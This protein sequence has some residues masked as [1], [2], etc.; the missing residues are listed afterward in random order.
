MNDPKIPSRAEAFDS[1]LPD[2]SSPEFNDFVK[3]RYGDD[4]SIIHAS[5]DTNGPPFVL[6]DALRFNATAEDAAIGVADDSGIATYSKFSLVFEPGNEPK[7]EALSD[8]DRELFRAST[9][10]EFVPTHAIIVTDASTVD[11]TTQAGT[12]GF[13]MGDFQVLVTG[14]VTMRKDRV[15]APKVPFTQMLHYTRFH[16]EIDCDLT[17]EIVK[18]SATDSSEQVF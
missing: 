3:A 7:I 13:V 1:P 16:R 6:L 9:G 11:A 17:P 10:G 18:E 14:G 15:W 8:A 4:I 12:Y 5:D 2:P